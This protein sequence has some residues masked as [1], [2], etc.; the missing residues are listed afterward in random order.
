MEQNDIEQ[1]SF[2]EALQ[3][4]TKLVEKLELGKLSLEESVQAFEQGVRL[5]RR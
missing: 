1:L 3:A 4:M 2:E 5:S